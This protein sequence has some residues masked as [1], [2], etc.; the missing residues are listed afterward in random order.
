MKRNPMR[1]L[2]VSRYGYPDGTGGGQTSGREIALSVAKQGCIVRF[3]CMR[4]GIN[5]P[6][7]EIDGEMM[8]MRYPYKRNGPRRYSNLWPTFRQLRDIIRKEAVSFNPDVVH[9]LNFD[10]VVY[11]AQE[12]SRLG[13]PSVVT[14]NGPGFFCGT[15]NG[16]HSDWSPC[17]DCNRMFRDSLALWGPVRGMAWWFYHQWLFLQLR[18]AYKNVG[19]FVAVSRQIGNGLLSMGVSPDK[20]RI[21]HNPIDV[22]IMKEVC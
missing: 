10:S 6:V 22:V 2:F 5:A 16:V 17:L 4:E 7:E 9:L 12:C 19:C 20:I 11:G 18:K 15:R 14:V 1:V 21:V 8:V 13:I 3:V